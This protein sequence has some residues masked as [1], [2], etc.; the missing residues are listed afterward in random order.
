MGPSPQGICCSF[1]QQTPLSVHWALGTSL[2]TWS[3]SSGCQTDTRPHSE[4]CRGA[5]THHTVFFPFFFFFFAANCTAAPGLGPSPSYTL[6]A[7]R[8]FLPQRK[9]SS[10]SN[11]TP[12]ALCR[13]LFKCNHFL[14]ETVSN[15]KGRVWAVPCESLF[16][17]PGTENRRE[18]PQQTSRVM[19]T[20]FPLLLRY[21]PHHVSV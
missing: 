16:G 11:E 3:Q 17:W 6:Y 12:T 1:S 10:P 8:Y 21:N 2:N 19:Q 9:C 7:K 18:V 13:A 20:F 4:G 15:F 5:G 14:L